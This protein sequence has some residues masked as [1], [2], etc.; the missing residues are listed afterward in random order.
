MARSVRIL[1]VAAILLLPLVVQATPAA[2]TGHG[3]ISVTAV[4]QDGAPIPALRVRVVRVSAEW[5]TAAHEFTDSHGEVVV[6]VEP[7]A[8]KVAFAGL[9]WSD[10]YLEEWWDDEPG[11]DDADVITV[12]E[13]SDIHLH[14]ALQLGGFVAGRVFDAATGDPLRTVPMIWN[15]DLTQGKGHS[16]W[17]TDSNGYFVIQGVP[18]GVFHVCVDAIGPYVAMCY[19][20]RFLT[21]D[22]DPVHV[23]AGEVTDGI[24]FPMVIGGALQGTIYSEDE[25]HAARGHDGTRHQPDDRTPLRI[26]AHEP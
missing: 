4:D 7:G 10:A 22:A 2:S 9:D 5:D 12:T 15:D 16:A 17:R 3:T 26:R 18:T 20:G 8:Y 19:D 6:A 23:I 1:V 11:F 21:Q 25:P 24:D 14:A 13:S